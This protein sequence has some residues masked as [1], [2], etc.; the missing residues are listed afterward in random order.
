[1]LELWFHFKDPKDRMADHHRP[2]KT[3]PVRSAPPAIS[4]AA[5]AVIEGL[6][7]RTRFVEPNL[8]ADWPSIVGSEAAALCRP[9]RMTGGRADRT[10]EVVAANSAAAAKIRFAAE[11]L[12]RRVND[13]LGPGTIG[14]IAVRQRGA[15]NPDPGPGGAATL[16]RFRRT[17]GPAGNRP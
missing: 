17:G 11:D 1:M 8:G 7:R 14:R 10:L 4:G 6:A 5:R 3:R 9:G 15:P 13:H 2:I 12:R 16:S